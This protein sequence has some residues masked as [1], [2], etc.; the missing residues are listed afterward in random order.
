VASKTILFNQLTRERLRE[1]APSAMVVLPVGATEQHGPHLPVGTDAI[2]VERI[3]RD[4]AS[5]ASEQ[6]P[7]LV[8][9][10]LFYGSS[11]HHLPFGGTMSI[12][13]ETYLQ[14]VKD[15]VESLITS[16]FR[17][18]FVLNGHGGNH[19]LI[20]LA[21]R[22]LALQHAVSL[23]A[24]SYWDIAMETLRTREELRDFLIPGHASCFETSLIM[25]LH[26]ELVQEPRPH[27]DTDPTT[28][29]STK[30]RHEYHGFLERI[31]GY[32]DS[33]ANASA[34][35]GRIYLEMC[36]SA[37]SNAFVSFYRETDE[38]GILKN[39]EP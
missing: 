13:T 19:E 26:S 20:Q 31:D 22:D 23:A 1:L 11:H 35:L 5:R 6:I 29:P 10:T 33:P 3:S 38:F 9:P 15:L 7:I 30:I 24:A 36:S 2:A 14:V 4:A 37:V 39:R 25:A 28:R 18:A 21:V 12:K 16:G 27:R 17:R 8:A 34:E 32:T